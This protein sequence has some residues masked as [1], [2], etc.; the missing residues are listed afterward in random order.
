MNKSQL[1]GY[2]LMVR[3]I[4]LGCLLFIT[5]Y[6]I[7]ATF[8]G[9]VKTY[10]HFPIRNA[11]VYIGNDT[12]FTNI[13]GRF[14]LESQSVLNDYSGL[15][16]HTRPR[17]QVTNDRI[18]VETEKDVT[19]RIRA[20]DLRGNLV[21]S[22]SGKKKAVLKEK[23][24]KTAGV[25]VYTITVNGKSY[26]FRQLSPSMALVGSSDRIHHEKSERPF[27]GK[28]VADKTCEIWA[29]KDGYIKMSAS[30]LDCAGETDISIVLDTNMIFT[31]TNP[32][33]GPAA[34]NPDGN[35]PVPD[36]AK[37]EDISN[38]DH[39]IGNGTPESCTADDFIDAVAEGGV[40]VFNTGGKPVT[41]TLDEPAKV[42]NKKFSPEKPKLVIDGGGLVTLSGGGKT[43]I[44]F[45]NTCEKDLGW[46]TP[47]CQNQSF[48]QLTVQNLTFIDGNSR[49]EEKYHGGGAIWARGGR[50]KAVNCRF[51]NNSCIF[52]GP[53]H[54]GAA[55]RVLSQHEGKPAY[56]VNCTFGGAEG[57]GNA[58]SN[59]GGIGSI[60]VSW[61]V[62]NCLFTHNRALGNRGNPA[63]DGT[64]GGGSGGAIY[65]DGNEMTLSVYGTRIEQNEA[66]AYGSAIFFVTNNH[67]GDIHI[68]NTV[69]QNNIGGGWHILPGIAMH[70]DTKRQV[71]NSTLE[72]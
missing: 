8:S 22:V 70:D 33:E 40:I 64:P 54:A 38:P 37:L 29:S 13:R 6:T 34:G 42:F 59:G 17:I 65:N 69:I 43:R 44:L 72:E 3:V 68:E 27:L 62:I 47:H 2:S 31:P 25:R 5:Q 12:V 9:T 30:Q 19:L 51:F 58:G 32:L 71:I 46:A 56:L 1:L 11:A 45:M 28:S 16:P 24:L 36:D 61:T 49:N 10:S 15:F 35:W 26:S 48:P 7:A 23:S 4:S 39:T 21:A 14:K 60:H 66:K 41:I 53:D 52:T 67:T 50:F 63:V 57:F 18:S 20:F 55:I